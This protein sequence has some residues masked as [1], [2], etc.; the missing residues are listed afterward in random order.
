MHQ[1]LKNLSFDPYF[2]FWSD[3][4]L[5]NRLNLINLEGPEALKRKINIWYMVSSADESF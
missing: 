1:M 2:N 5:K 3:K 4:K